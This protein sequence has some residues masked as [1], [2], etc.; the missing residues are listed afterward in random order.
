MLPAFGLNVKQA[1]DETIQSRHGSPS[2]LPASAGHWRRALAVW[3]V[4]LIGF[5][6]AAPFAAVPLVRSDAFVVAIH[7][8]LVTTNLVTAYLLYGQFAISGGY[9]ILVLASGYLFAGIVI[10][11]Y[12]LAFPGVITTTGIFGSLQATPWLN[13]F[14]HIGFAIAAMAYA[15]LKERPRDHEEVK[16]P[17]MAIG[18]GVALVIG[19]AAA[20][21]WICINAEKWLPTLFVSDVRGISNLQYYGGSIALSAAI[22]LI[23]LWK[24]RRT[25]L[26][27]WLLVALWAEISEPIMATVLNSSRFTVGFYSSRVF[28]VVTSTAVLA[29]LIANMILLQRKLSMSVDLLQRERDSKM[30]SIEAAIASLSHE[31]RQPLGAISLNSE[32]GL[33]LVRQPMPDLSEIEKIFA[34]IRQDS[35][36]V[37]LILSSV[38]SLFKA[39]DQPPQSL[40][41]NEIALTSVRMF[42]R[43]MISRGI[44]M[45]LKLA[46]ELPDIQGHPGHL[47][48]LA[49]NLLQNAI[50]AMDN[51]SNRAKMIRITTKRADSRSINV[52]VEDTGAGIAPTEV[53]RIFDAFVSTK[54]Q[55]RGL[56]LP[57]CRVIVD[58]HGGHIAVTSKLGKGARVEVVLPIN[59]PDG[60]PVHFAT[61]R[62]PLSSA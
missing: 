31:V 30:M 44:T 8:I 2:T 17:A 37:S 47:V 43:D 14:W 48:E 13:V 6:M 15:F 26:D 10:V 19:L 45:D 50:D 36:S 53:D 22:A 32:S 34:D 3:A 9:S 46:S 39:T 24:R 23:V 16:A 25:V 28:S 21:S 54:G 20:A 7:V 11:P 42:E 49:M 57:L 1:N 4:L 35:Q 52:V 58:R 12:S 27:V 5:L 40:N 38:R 18:Y 41:F 61:V 59:H 55:G 62:A 56:G 60:Q 29:A 51:G 33:Q